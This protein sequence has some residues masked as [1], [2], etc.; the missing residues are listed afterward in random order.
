MHSELS[1]GK[2]PVIWPVS[3]MFY[4]RSSLISVQI[5]LLIQSVRFKEEI[6][7]QNVNRMISSVIQ[8]LETQKTF[9]Q[10]LNVSVGIDSQGVYSATTMYLKNQQAED[11]GFRP[12]S[13]DI[14]L[15]PCST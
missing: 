12:I 3:Y 14:A 15:S 7:V 5:I 4:A 2:S 10:V 9:N 11:K 8:K 6:F 1:T 13:V